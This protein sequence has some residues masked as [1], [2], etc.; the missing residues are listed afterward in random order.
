MA[1]DKFAMCPGGTG[2]KVKFCAGNCLPQL[3]R[4]EKLITA[5]QSRAARQQVTTWLERDPN[6][7]CLWAYKCLLDRAAG[8]VEDHAKSAAE[9]VRLFPDS[10]IALAELAIAQILEN[11]FQE[12]SESLARCVEQCEAQGYFYYRVVAA[13]T[14]VA[15]WL[16]E[17]GHIPAAIAYLWI[18]SHRYDPQNHTETD[19]ILQQLYHRKD[20]PLELRQMPTTGLF[21]DELRDL[22]SRVYQ[23]VVRFRFALAEQEVQRYLETNPEEPQA[24]F[25]LGNLRLWQINY[26][27]AAEA[28]LRC[29]QLD[30]TGPL[31]MVALL[32]ATIL[33][34][35]GFGDTENLYLL[36]YEVSD[37]ER[38]KEALFSDPHLD[39]VPPES[40]SQTN[41][42]GLTEPQFLLLR[43]PR[44]DGF[45][46]L[47]RDLDEPRPPLVS[48]VLYSRSRD[49]E[50]AQIVLTGV[51]ESDR[52]WVETRARQWCGDEEL[53]VLEESV[54]TTDSRILRMLRDVSSVSSRFLDGKW[55]DVESRLVESIPKWRWPVLEPLTLEEAARDP[56]K[57]QW[58][59]ILLAHILQEIP[60]R[61]IAR[62]LHEVWQKLHLDF[63]Q[64]ELTRFIDKTADPLL[65]HFI[66]PARLSD[67]Q[68]SAVC[69]LLFLY[70]QVPLLER[71]R[72]EVLQRRDRL[73]PEL[74]Y[75]VYEVHAAVF[76]R[77]RQQEWLTIHPELEEMITYCEQHNL[78]H[79]RLHELDLVG[80]VGILASKST[81]TEIKK[82]ALPFFEKL[83]EHLVRHHVNDPEIGPMVRDYWHKL[84]QMA[85]AF[86][87]SLTGGRSLD[88]LTQ[89]QIWTPDA[90][91]GPESRLA[92]PEPKKIWVP[93]MD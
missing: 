35:N 73:D 91:P 81:S 32:R 4:L 76:V 56:Q 74:V 63:D 42:R 61:H 64:E 46:Q 80:L 13:M 22:D 37:P 25:C 43:Y 87:A 50:P 2:K 36:R 53:K 82:Q 45:E 10:P 38:T 20:V 71:F 9:F 19:E 65:I 79:G 89:P 84:T 47:L 55:T 34:K 8:C 15:E 31:G 85:L 11:R 51:S 75:F 28:Y 21:K 69:K 48:Y 26:P 52:S 92:Q 16:A 5:D 72:P 44:S 93:G 12:A 3:E 54:F 49:D 62:V 90:E 83:L 23:H 77:T 58:A 70:Q 30:Q 60:D 39:H 24:W 17:Q 67:E 27:G 1:I 18:A 33:K 41:D 6:R 57:K 66:D 68:L 7:A 78:S 14:T 88:E 86:K 59:R 40:P 29:A